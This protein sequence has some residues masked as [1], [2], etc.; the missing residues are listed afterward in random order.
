MV[1]YQPIWH[2]LR[3]DAEQLLFSS[4]VDLDIDEAVQ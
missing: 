3:L 1:A 4:H 2:L